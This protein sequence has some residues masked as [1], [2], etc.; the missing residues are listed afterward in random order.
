VTLTLTSKSTWTSL[1]ASS[2]QELQGS[3][4]IVHRLLPRI[5]CVVVVIE[6]T[7]KHSIA[8]IHH[9]ATRTTSSSSTKSALDRHE[10]SYMLVVSV[11]IVTHTSSNGKVQHLQYSK[12]VAHM[13]LIKEI[14]E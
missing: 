14:S 8:Y 11:L 7:P 10:T 9:P 12:Y 4:K 13:K 6:P 5:I 1:D 3:N 2:R